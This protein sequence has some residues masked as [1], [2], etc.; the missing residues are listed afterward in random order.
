LAVTAEPAFNCIIAVPMPLAAGTRLGPYEVIALLGAGGMGEVYRG[1]DPRMG[2]DVAI[3]VLP[4]DV[5]ADLTRVRRFEQEARAAAALNHPNILSVYDVGQHDGAAYLVSELLDG[6]T[7][8]SRLRRLSPAA[9]QP[10][11]APRLQRALTSRKA[12]EY[13]VQIARGLAAAHEKAIV[14]RDLKPENLFITTNERVKILDFGLAEL[15]SSSPTQ[16]DG[17]AT[18]ADTAVGTVLGTV[19]YMAP[20][21]VRGLAADHRSDIFALGSMLYEMLSGTRAFGGATSADVMTAVLN[22][23]P[24]EAPLAERHVRPALAR[25]VRRCL[26]KNPAAR[27]QS[28]EDLAFALEGLS[29]SS[30]AGDAS[31]LPRRRSPSWLPWG[32]LAATVVALIAASALALTLYPRPRVEPR[33]VR[34]EIASPG[35]LSFSSTGTLVAV[36]PDSSRVAILEPSGTAPAVDSSAGFARR[37]ATGGHRRHPRAVLVTRRSIHRVLRVWQAAE[38]GGQRR[39]GRGRDERVQ[40]PSRRRVE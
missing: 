5:S 18:V 30:D 28:T 40:H 27:F 6:E 38:D 9:D 24:P 14:H 22:E 37:S 25:V 10:A 39:A 31:P 33:P 32:L 13:A 34:F 4:Q 11:L 3:T 8:R 20:E 7:L 12:V 21:Q 15:E 16:A 35:N 36:S 17:A 29:T 19:G 1:H 26:E 23:E 2:R